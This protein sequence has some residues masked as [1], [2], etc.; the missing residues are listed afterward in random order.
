DEKKEVLRLARPRLSAADKWVSRFTVQPLEKGQWVGF[1]LD[2]STNRRF[3]LG[4]YTI[5]HNTESG[6]R[7]MVLHAFEQPEECRPIPWAIVRD[8]WRN[9]ER[10]T[11]RSIIF[12]HP[13]S[14]AE[15][16]RPLIRISGGGEKVF[17]PG[18]LEIELFGVDSLG[19]LNR[20]QSMQLAGL[21]LEEPSPA[22]QEIGGG[23]DERVL[24]MGV[25]SLRYPCKW[26]TVQVTG[27]YPDESHWVWQ[28]YGV[29]KLGR[30]IRIPRG[31]NPHLPAG[32]REMME[33]AFSGDKGLLD[34]L[35]YGQPGFVQQGEPV[36]P[37]YNPEIHRAKVV[38]EPYPGARGYRFWD[39]WL[40]PTCVVAQLIPS[41]QLQILEVF[42]GERMGMLQLVREFV[43]PAM[44]T[45][46]KAIYEWEDIGDPTIANYDQSNFDYNQTAAA[47]IERELDTIFRPGE[48]LWQPRREALRTAFSIVEPFP[49]VVLSGGEKT[50]ILHKALRGGWH[51][52]VLPSGG[53]AA[54]VPV[55]DKYSHCGDAL[56]YGLAD[57]LRDRER[58]HSDR[59]FDEIVDWVWNESGRCPVTG[60]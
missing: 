16:L 44:K 51:Y 34:R 9:L 11:L 3:L 40:N 10:T 17:I 12:P 56:S 50:E 25:S 15:K 27:N 4:D 36:V 52:R 49:F 20:F 26:V 5:T 48:R 32:Y 18:I 45:R 29:K 33:Q 24:T 7:R 43:K 30:L 60:Y 54:K 14:F 46:Y 41:G 53:V 59:D 55:K 31:E 57:A 37:N 2:E 38:L 28:R 22:V 39:G 35:V 58:L 6:I 1:T 8:T 23:L 47:V 21:W 13:G 42:T 19:D